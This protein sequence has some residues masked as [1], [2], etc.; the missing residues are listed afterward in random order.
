MWYLA[1]IGI[2]TY[3]PQNIYKGRVSVKKIIKSYTHKQCKCKKFGH[4]SVNQPYIWDL[5]TIHTSIDTYMHNIG[6]YLKAI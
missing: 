6:T 3:M 5:H 4:V 2:Y 1:N